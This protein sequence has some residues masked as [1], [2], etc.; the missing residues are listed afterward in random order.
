M[1]VAL[2][3]VVT[4]ASAPGRLAQYNLA[5]QISP[6]MLV[7]GIVGT[8]GQMEPITTYMGSMAGT[9]DANGNPV[10]A[11]FVPLPGATLIAQAIGEYPF[12]NQQ[13]AANSTIVQP[14]IISMEMIAPVNQAGGYATKQSALSGMQSTFAKHNAAGGT[15]TIATPAFVYYALVMTGMT[16]VTGEDGRQQQIRWQLDFRQPILT[17]AGAFA[18]QG[19][20]MNQI[21]NGSQ[22]GTPSWSGQTPASPANL[23]GVTA[24]LAAFGGTL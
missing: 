9:V 12:P 14:N 17:A 23:P 18:A 4:G 5:F 3:P 7:G 2:T 11:I 21:T 20:T 15:Y 1:S 10:G 19:A 13:V 8:Q 24:A 22:M 16:D 6:I